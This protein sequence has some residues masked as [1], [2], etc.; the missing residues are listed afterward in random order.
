MKT[1]FQLT[2][3]HEKFFPQF[4]GE[5]RCGCEG[6]EVAGE[7]D[8]CVDDKLADGFGELVLR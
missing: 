3:L 5:L 1:G 7:A 8:R 4:S 2:N 6:A